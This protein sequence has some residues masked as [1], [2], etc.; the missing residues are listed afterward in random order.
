MLSAVLSPALTLVRLPRVGHAQD[1]ALKKRWGK[2][3][4]P[5]HLLISHRKQRL[6]HR[7]TNNSGTR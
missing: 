1:A 5:M 6:A 4:I 7:I 2:N 3:K